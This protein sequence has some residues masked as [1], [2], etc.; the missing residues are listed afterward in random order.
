MKHFRTLTA[1]FLCAAILATA[2]ACSPATEDTDILDGVSYDVSDYEVSG[3][4]KLTVAF[5]TPATVPGGI[6]LPESIDSSLLETL[7]KRLNNQSFGCAMYYYDI[8]TGFS[9]SYNAERLFGAASLIKAP[10]LLYILDRV[11]KGELSLDMEMTY[12]AKIHKFGGTGSIKNMPDGTKLTLREVIEHI[13]IESDNS[14]FRMLYNTTDGLMSLIEFHQNA[15]RDF[16][17]PFVSNTYGS[18]L[19]AQGVGRIF[20]EIYHRADD[21]SEVFKWFVELLKEANANKFVKGGL[22]TDE[23]GE[24]IYEVAHKYG[25]DIK[26]LNDAA[27]VY[28]GDRPY[29][30]VILTD[31]TGVYSQSFMNRIST[32][33]YKIH[34]ELTGGR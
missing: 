4:A 2:S 18:V 13:C 25:E 15:M 23:S 17:A 7:N 27:I 21:G 22:P 31:Y 26:S 8:K 10:Y 1:A 20:T 14:A 30:L 28:Y 11:D 19:N 24:C 29:V 32:D 16:K 6:T 12:H 9:I 34:Q 33:V 5:P 3:E